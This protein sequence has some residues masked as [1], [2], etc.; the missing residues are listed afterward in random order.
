MQPQEIERI[1]RLA[2]RELGVGDVPVTIAAKSPD[3]FEVMLGGRAPITLVIRAGTGTTSQFVRQQI[4][5]QFPA[6]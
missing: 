5:E 2:L 6:R 3:S 4:F 1:V